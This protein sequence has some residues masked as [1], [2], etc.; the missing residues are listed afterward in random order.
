VSGKPGLAM[1]LLW[2][3]AH[4]YLGLVAL[5][6][7]IVAAVTGVLLV[8]DKAL[9]AALNP[10]LF[11]VPHSSVH[12]DSAA[13][14]ARLESAVTGLR[15]VGVPVQVPS[16]RAVLF[17]VASR[18]NAHASTA[19]LDYDQVFVNPIDGS[20]LGT[21]RDGPG[22]GRRHWI[23]DIYLLHS[24]L[25]AGKWGGRLMG[26]IG[27]LWLV[28][29]LV[30]LYL[31][32]PRR[33]PFFAKWKSAWRISWRSSWPR[34]MVDLHRVTGLWALV[35]MVVMAYSSFGIG[36]YYE[37]LQPLVRA[38]S[39]PRPSLFGTVP[40]LP[41]GHSPTIGFARAIDIA[42]ARARHDGLEWP[43]AAASYL[44]GRAVYGVM[45][46]RSG[47]EEYSGLG[48]ITYYLDDRTAAP[49]MVDD[50]YADNMG[51]KVLRATY[52]IH[53]G[54]IGGHATRWVVMVLGVLVLEMSITGL[55]VW[56]RR[57]RPQQRA[58]VVEV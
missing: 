38:V 46:T 48:P 33:G 5:A 58:R 9:D 18:E 23:Q 2:H 41:D 50:V 24:T 44:P 12:A 11:R 51:A 27:L 29:I 19:P 32:L 47:Q 10:D 49:K 7:L 13:L 3:Q 43:P 17:T 34:L 45:F 35:P 16:G 6:F 53:S 42:T 21:R 26:A 31:T 30:G 15:V 52:P 54:Q 20:I 28:E 39:P 36:L 56:W 57:R 25:F 37:A 55:L 1:R 4:K 22:Y 14:A 8:Y 40:A